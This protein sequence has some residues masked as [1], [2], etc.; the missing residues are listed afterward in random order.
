MD[1]VDGRAKVTG[2]ARY[3][4][5]NPIANV[6]HGVL[7]TSAIARGRIASIET[8][9][10]ERVPG[11]LA[12]MTHENAKKL[13]RPPD[14]G[15]RSRPATRVLQLLQDP[16]VRYANQPIAVVVAETFEAAREA[17]GLVLVRYDR[18]AHDVRLGERLDQAYVPKRAARPDQPPE[19]ARGDVDAAL[20][21]AEVKIDRVYT[22]AFE[23]HNPMEP[24]A[25]LAAWDGPARLTLYDATQGIFGCR[26]RVAEL[27][28]LRPDDVRVVSE[29]LGGGFGSKGPTWSHVVLA[30]IAARHVNRPVKLALARPQMFGPI[31]YRSRTRQAITIGARRDGTLTALRHDTVAQTSSFDEFME[32]ASM[33][34]RM[35]YACPNVRTSHQLIRSDIGTPSYMRAPGWA[36]GTFALE[37]AIDEIAY[38]V[39]MDPLAFRLKNFAERDPDKQR[40]WSS[41]TLRECYHVGA[42]RFGW[43]R[44]PSAP[45]TMRDGRARIGWGMATAVYPT[46]RSA[47]SARARLA[48]NGGV[49]VDAGTQD[50]GTGTY[51]IMTQIAAD[52]IGVPPERARFR[53]GDTNFPE[54]PVS[55]GSQTAASTGSAVH[56]AATAL[57]RK[58]IEMAVR[59]ARSPL[60]G[61]NPDDVVIEDGRLHAE[62]AASR[63]ETLAEFMARHPG[64]TVEMRAD[65][66][67]GE[68]HERYSMYAFGAQFAEVR[69]DADLGQIRVSRMVGVF[70]IG[71]ALNAKTARSQLFG[72][73]VWGIGL[74]LHEATLMDERLGR[75][76]NN[77]L[78]EYHVPVNA[79]IP[80]LDVSWIDQADDRANPIGVKGIGELGIT[81]SAAAVANAVFHA[82]GKRVRD[83]PIT[84][85]KLL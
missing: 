12:V 11:V 17:A 1:R 29:Y 23:T 75:V 73:M 42:E 77:N 14:A 30:A 26:Q 13:S 83:V 15:D 62:N 7:V 19:S 58:V 21:D 85:D 22:T 82:T 46:H 44:R 9:A 79:D 28:G 74:A 45:G 5:E 4:M 52:A 81:G 3:A 36:P 80:M 33:P 51:T 35:L 60:S 25:T 54:T 40:P 10:A 69:V 84:L 27:L 72:G 47:A 16:A 2:R 50:L 34:S 32:P 18:Q 68:E 76:V 41:N 71:R 66:K 70:D 6:A 39:E 56:Q 43:N 37:C 48:P 63:G 53:L 8:R 67:P 64:E 20:V 78:A 24:H 38:A 31:G 59:D 49:V 55:G 57:R 61:V 65:A